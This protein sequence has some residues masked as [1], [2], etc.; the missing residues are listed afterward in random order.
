MGTPTRAVPCEGGAVREFPGQGRPADLPA[1]IDRAPIG[2]MQY[3]IFT[4]CA[5]ASLLDGIDTQSIG[6][7]APLLSR[8]LGLDRAALGLVF[9]LT[10]VGGIVGSLAFG[11]LGDRFGRKPVVIAGLVLIALFTWATRFSAGFASLAAI[12]ILAG[13]ALSGV[14]PCVLALASE[15]A[16]ARARGTVVPLVYAAFPVGAAAGGLFNAALLAR[17][18]WPSMFYA[19][20]VSALAVAILFAVFVPESL[21]FLASGNKRG[22]VAHILRRI[23]PAGVVPAGPA[24]FSPDSSSAVGRSGAGRGQ[25]E[26]LARLFGPGLL[27]STLALSMLYF[28]AFAITRTLA[29]W[30]PTLVT[31]GGINAA[32]APVVLSAFNTGSVFGML[33]TGLVVGVLGATRSIAPAMALAVVLLASMSLVGTLSA[34]SVLAAGVGFLAGVADAGAHAIATRVFPPE[35]RSTGVGWCIAVSRVGQAIMPSIVGGMLSASLPPSSIYL[36][37]AVLPAGTC[38]SAMILSR[39]MRR[40]EGRHRSLMTGS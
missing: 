39:H 17:Y 32:L 23:D 20:A 16:P 5:L 18:G 30:L 36:V 19:G 14:M 27:A 13:L 28:F 29:A 33:L 31:D 40:E 10:Q 34:L 2:A 24:P 7:A 3:R 22:H 38:L 8:D 35:M 21:T 25:R 4:A 9:S 6:I 15:Y 11:W 37:L 26:V 12:R 1:L